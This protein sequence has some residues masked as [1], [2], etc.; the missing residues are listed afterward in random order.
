MDY[1]KL[2]PNLDTILHYFADSYVEFW[3]QTM[4]ILL[5]FRQHNNSLNDNMLITS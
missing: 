3:A 5:F 4:Y 2:I 1:D